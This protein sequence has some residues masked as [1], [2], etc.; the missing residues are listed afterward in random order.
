MGFARVDSNKHAVLRKVDASQNELWM[1]TYIV[2]SG[3]SYIV[4]GSFTL[5]IQ[6]NYIYFLINK[7]AEYG[8]FKLKASDGS[9]FAGVVQNGV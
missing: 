3:N 2:P 9:F 7:I 4:V 1:K 8:I 6:Q 5:D